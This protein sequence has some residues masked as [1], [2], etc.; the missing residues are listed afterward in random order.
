MKRSIIVLVALISAFVTVRAQ[1]P[2]TTWPYV[3]SDFEQGT[4]NFTKKG[5]KG[6]LFNICIDGARLHFID[7]DLVKSAS[8]GEVMSVMIGKDLFQNVLGRMVKVL[9]K[10]EKCLVVEDNE[11]DFATLNSTEAAYGS[12]SNTLGNMS[13]SSLEGIGGSNSSS[14][15]N[16]ME[17]KHNKD[18]GKEL[19]L[20]VKKYIVVKGHKIFCAKKDIMETAPDKA[21]MKQYFKENSVKWKDEVSLMALGDF[22][23]EQL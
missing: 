11:I 19:P 22:L 18:Q 3:Y 12:S 8:P 9:A 14:S 4:V 13:L 5:Q 2:T 17:L 15:L 23:Y 1:G 20:I 21:A 16:H 6:G 10:S 7:G